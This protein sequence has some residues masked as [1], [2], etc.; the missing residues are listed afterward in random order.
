MIATIL[1]IH[2]LGK[3]I[4]GLRGGGGIEG[5]KGANGTA[6]RGYGNSKFIFFLRKNKFLVYFYKFERSSIFGF[7][8]L[9]LI[10]LK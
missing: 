4:S 10:I 5:Y 7:T 9:W 8:N 6:H 3:L 1:P 2:T